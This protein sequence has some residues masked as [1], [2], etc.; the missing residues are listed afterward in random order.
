M[1]KAFVKESDEAE[2]L[3]LP[4]VAAVAGFK[5]YMTPAGYRALRDEFEHLVKV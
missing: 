1:S 4:E 2:D 5:N 3:E